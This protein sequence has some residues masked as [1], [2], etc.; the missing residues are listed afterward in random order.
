MNDADSFWA[1]LAE[2][3]IGILLIILSILVFYFTTTSSVLSVFSGVFIF[4]G[5]GILVS[6][7]FLMIVRPPD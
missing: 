1:M 2:K 5:I 6:G 7:A 4:I 3:A